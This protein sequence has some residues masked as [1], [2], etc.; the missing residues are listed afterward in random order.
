MQFCRRTDLVTEAVM[1]PL[2]RFD[3]DAAI[4]FSDILTVPQA[5]GADLSVEPN[6]G[7]IVKDP[8]TTEL[9]IAKLR[10]DA[11]DEL[12]YVFDAVKSIKK[13]LNDDVPLIGFAGS[14]WTIATYLVEGGSSKLFQVIKK[15]M[16]S[17][18]AMLRHLL[19]KITELTIAYLNAQIEA[20]VDVI[21]VFDSWG[22]VLSTPA[23]HEFSL[24]YL[25]LIV[26]GVYHEY[27]GRKI[28]IILFT[29]GGG[30]WLQS[31]ANTGCD[32]LGL[33]WTVDLATAFDTVNGK[34]ALQGNIDPSVLLSTPI[35]VR[36]ET[37]RI[38]NEAGNKPGFI[39]N[40]G[41]GID[42]KTPI[43]NVNAMM[44]AI[45]AYSC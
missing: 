17:A 27:D 30:Q 25:K 14:P 15:M 3:L 39:V 42:R 7:P 16:Y 1:Q 45:K 33:D 9:Q 11:I 37:Q 36:D 29:K 43:D 35:A 22:G 6:I 13:A 41:H 40:L 12:D 24:R 2:R 18:P 10:A 34:V 4:L 38:L 32:A 5:M 20:G 31:I 26:D 21:Q 28:P 19:L 44:Q 8:I 23:Y